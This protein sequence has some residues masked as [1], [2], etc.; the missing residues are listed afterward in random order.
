MAS[1][2]D[3]FAGHM[4]YEAGL[5][6]PKVYLYRDGRDVALSMWKAKS[7]QHKRDRGLSFS[8]FLRLHMDWYATPGKM[9]NPGISIVQHWKKHVDSWRRARNTLFI[10][11]ESMLNNTQGGLRKIAK[12]AKFKI[13]KIPD[14]LK[15]VGPN[16]SGDYRTGKWRDVFS[17]KDLDYFYK[18][19]PK[20]HWCL[21][22]D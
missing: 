16:P 8:E 20:K 15:G 14:N 1:D 18:I 12:F 19:V 17:K 9:A 4:F 2:R 6:G 11:Y 10:S 22:N 13:R 3:I 21:Y 5:S 7:L